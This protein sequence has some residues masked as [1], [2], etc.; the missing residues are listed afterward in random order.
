M[1]NVT[2]CIVFVLLVLSCS[3]TESVSQ[4]SFQGFP[5]GNYTPDFGYLYKYLKEDGS[6][7]WDRFYN[8]MNSVPRNYYVYFKTRTMISNA[9]PNLYLHTD[10][11]NDYI[12]VF[13][14]GYKSV[15][16]MFSKWNYTNAKENSWMS[17]GNGAVAFNKMTEYWNFEIK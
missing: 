13:E 5:K 17:F 12:F 1:K 10:S 3:S 8:N 9:K 11:N 16:A 15:E 7:D 4:N 6:L 2:I 14:N